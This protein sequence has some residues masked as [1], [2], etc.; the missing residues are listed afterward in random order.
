MSDATLRELERAS[1][2][3][4]TGQAWARLALARARA[5][6][7]GRRAA[8]QALLRDPAAPVRELLPRDDAPA[9]R[10]LAEVAL[11]P[12]RVPT[13]LLRAP[14]HDVRDLGRGRALLVATDELIAVDLFGGEVVWR[15][16]RRDVL[17]GLGGPAVVGG[18]I[19]ELCG[20]ASG[21]RVE[22]RSAATGASGGRLVLPDALRHPALP[23]VALVPLTEARCALV[24]RWESWRAVWLDLEAGRLLGT[25]DL[26]SE[27]APEAGE[28]VAPRWLLRSVVAGGALLASRGGALEAWEPDGRARWT[29]DTGG[30]AC[31]PLAAGGGLVAASVASTAGAEPERVDVVTADGG[32][33]LGSV[34]RG[35]DGAGLLA[36]QLLVLA[37]PD[38]GGGQRLA[39]WSAAGERRWSA[40]AT[41]PREHGLALHAAGDVI[42]VVRSVLG[43]DLAPRALDATALD[44]DTGAVLWS[45]RSEDLEGDETAVLPLGGLLV[46]VGPPSGWIRKHT[47]LRR[48]GPA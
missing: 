13:G 38:P 27:R 46:A 26:G 14:P 23:G 12:L 19:A 21:P 17:P 10:S 4:T 33:L 41:F 29:H 40:E 5:G 45:R 30:A 2:D 47:P 43:A 6:L 42:V 22:W 36:G 11:E 34:A 39:A 8:V 35:R 3:D 9:P 37:E 25:T 44:R 15:G 48:I 31:A 1:R 20:G 32:R 28:W 7:D 24:G 16:A 18:R